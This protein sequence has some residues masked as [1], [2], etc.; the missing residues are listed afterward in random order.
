MTF[1]LFYAI[2]EKS[3]LKSCRPSKNKRANDRSALQR[4]FK[5][6]ALVCKVY[7]VRSSTLNI[8][9]GYILS[10]SL[11]FNVGYRTDAEVIARLGRMH[12]GS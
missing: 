12:T 3:W 10:K 5:Q 4:K 8:S 1:V 6:F 11:Q 2:D 9:N 7:S